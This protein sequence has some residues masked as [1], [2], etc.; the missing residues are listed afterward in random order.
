MVVQYCVYN[1]E[2]ILN[3]DESQRKNTVFREDYG[4][5]WEISRRYSE[6]HAL[7][8]IIRSFYPEKLPL[9]EKTAV[10]NTTQ[11]HIE[12]RRRALGVYM[13][14]LLENKLMH[15]D[16]RCVAAVLLFLQKD[17][18]K[19]RRL[20]RGQIN[21]SRFVGSHEPRTGSE[22]RTIFRTRAN[23]PLLDGC[24]GVARHLFLPTLDDAI[25]R[26]ITVQLN[27]LLCEGSVTED[28][29]ILHEVLFGEIPPERTHD[30]M[31]EDEAKA[32][33]LLKDLLPAALRRVMGDDCCDDSI[34]AL[35]GYLHSSVLNCQ[36]MCRI[37]D[38]F[39]ELLFPELSTTPEHRHNT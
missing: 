18:T 27:N 12:E 9:P 20:A 33:K 38:A 14:A 21:I 2:V 32:R 37:L 24:L 16:Q 39:F 8:R 29:A 31:A 34:D 22:V 28:I 13:Q 11:K 3:P 19:F 1:M 23:A 6:F 4:N 5:M 15:L 7:D 30:E 25:Q 36:L 17:G 26:F 10:R 35:L